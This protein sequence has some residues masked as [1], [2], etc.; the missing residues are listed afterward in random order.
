MRKPICDG[1][2][3]RPVDPPEY[4]EKSMSNKA[5]WIV[6]RVKA[7]LEKDGFRRNTSQSFGSG[8]M[9]D[10]LQ[11]IA[12]IYSGDRPDE[13]SIVVD[14]TQVVSCDDWRKNPV[15]F[16]VKYTSDNSIYWEIQEIDGAMGDSGEDTDEFFGW[17]EYMISEN[18][19]FSIE[20]G[21]IDPT[22]EF[23]YDNYGGEPPISAGERWTQAFNEKRSLKS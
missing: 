6:T 10:V 20:F 1:T 14:A 22:P 5:E 9:Q 23:L 12:D 11:M 4:W 8:E 3:P 18:K 7:K 19:K 17:A 21:D 13:C 15:Y 16:K 2:F